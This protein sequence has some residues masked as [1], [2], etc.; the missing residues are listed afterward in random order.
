MELIMFKSILIPV[1]IAEP[2][3]ANAAFAQALEIARISKARLTLLYVRSLVPVS[4]MEFAPPDFDQIEQK[5]TRELVS[6]MAAKLDYPQDMISTAVR[7]GS[8]YSEVLALAD[9]MKADL[10][11]VGSQRPTMATYLIGSNAKNIVRHAPCSV[12]VVRGVT[13]AS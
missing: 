8:V 4:Y 7:L 9:E 1:D 3:L 2:E 10:I 12:L 11:V 5:Q 13:A 6:A